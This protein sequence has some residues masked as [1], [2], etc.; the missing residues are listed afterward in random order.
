MKMVS[1][2]DLAHETATYVLATSSEN[3]NT[4]ARDRAN[5]VLISLANMPY[6]ILDMGYQDFDYLLKLCT[7]FL[8]TYYVPISD[9]ALISVLYQI[10]SE[11]ITSINDNTVMS[12]AQK[13]IWALAKKV[14][15]FRVNHFMMPLTLISSS[16]DSE[17]MLYSFIIHAVKDDATFVDF[18]HVLKAHAVLK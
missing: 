5:E 15:T 3:G 7:S 8:R 11:C 4:F 6:F 1:L 9:S 10:L 18:V 17:S 14:S 16:T 12:T 13:E 2:L